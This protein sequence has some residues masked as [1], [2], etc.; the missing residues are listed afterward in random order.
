M[1]SVVTL[2]LINREPHNFIECFVGLCIFGIDSEQNIAQYVIHYWKHS[3]Q[4]LYIKA[5]YYSRF[6]VQTFDKLLRIDN[7][8]EAYVR[9]QNKAKIHWVFDYRVEILLL[10]ARESNIAFK[11]GMYVPVTVS[12]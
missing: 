8:S 12:S 4:I 3:G 6:F 9:R 10:V 2:Q 5:I 7:Q 11:Q 1:T